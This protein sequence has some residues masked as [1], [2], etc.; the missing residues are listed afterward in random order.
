VTDPSNGLQ[1][2]KAVPVNNQLV[3]IPLPPTGGLTKFI[4]P[5]FC[6]GRVYVSDSKGNVICLGSPVALPLQCSQPVDYGN[7]NIGSSAM[8]TITCKALIAITSVNGCTTGDTNW[9]CINSTLPKGSIAQGATFSF[10]V[11]WDLTHATVSDIPN[12]SFGRVQPGVASTSLDIYTTN[13]APQYSTIYPISLVGTEVSSGAYLTIIPVEVDLGG[14]VLGSGGTNSMLTGSVVVSNVGSQVLTFVGLAWTPN[15]D[16]NDG[17]V[18]FTNIT[19]TSGDL[20]NGFNSNSFP[21]VGTTIAQGKS[22]TIPLKFTAVKT[23][24]YTTF[25][26][27]WTNGGSSYVLLS[28]SVA[29]A[30]IADIAVSFPEGYRSS[31]PLIMDFGD[32]FAGTT[33]TRNIK[34]CNSG[35]SALSITKSK[36]PDESEVFAPNEATDLHEGQN[37]DAGTCALGQVT[38]NAAPLGVNRPD[39]TVSGNWILN[40]EYAARFL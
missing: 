37:I 29:T 36:P 30:P 14:V 24:T 31:Q 13:A 7:V 21:V 22:L 32:I 27:F 26:Q 19:A 28:A 25:V 9:K 38:V 5:A 34:I 2:F 40:T 3:S 39:H 35:G 17:R 12:A 33:Q 10:P 16:P 8:Q 1:A 15:V 18:A 4:R 23:G 11:T 6:D 20:G